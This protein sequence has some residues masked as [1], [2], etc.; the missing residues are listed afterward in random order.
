MSVIGVDEVGRGCLA[1]DMLVVAARSCT[2]LPIGLKDSKLLSKTQREYFFKIIRDACDIGEGWV[3]APEIDKL[4]LT[5]ATKLGV[6]RALE[7]VGARDDEVITID[8]HIN[9]T[10]KKFYNSRSIIKADNLIPEVSAA[11]IFAKVTRD[12]YMKKIS[13]EYQGY[14]FEK[15]M[16][17]GTRFHI[18]ALR[19]LGS[20]DSIHRNSFNNTS[21][22]LAK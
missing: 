9:F 6:A 8:G 5:E 10:P 13:L 7:A 4:G 2:E 20:L 3:T 22:E 11:S 17:Y 19:E 16:G 12:A 21:S 18:N 15:N 14:G 1:G